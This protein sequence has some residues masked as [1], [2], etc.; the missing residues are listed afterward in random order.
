MTQPDYTSRTPTIDAAR[1]IAAGHLA[2][3]LPRR[4]AHVQAVG[5]KAERLGAVLFGTQDARLLAAAGWLHDI[6]YAPALAKTGFH[7]LDGA[8][9]LREAG[10]GGQLVALV[11]H[12][13]CA[14]KEAAVRGLAH[15]LTAFPREES[16]IADALWYA[17]MTTGPDGQDFDVAGRLAEIRS[18][19][20]VD[21]PVGRFI[22][23]AEADIMA[24]GER[25][26][27]RLKVAVA[28]PLPE[29]W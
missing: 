5:A 27:A 23:R 8:R 16:A 22:E 2:E 11:A 13:S 25:T 12:H 26:V 14:H 7:P 18:R 29:N 1:D 20:G 10:Y 4:W 3:A 19:Y 9:W 24:A 15:E 17:D 21:H 6:G 28:W